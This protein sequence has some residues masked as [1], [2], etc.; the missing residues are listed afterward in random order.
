MLDKV[1]EYKGVCVQGLV[2]VNCREVRRTVF[3]TPIQISHYTPYTARFFRR[4]QTHTWRFGQG[5]GTGGG[6]RSY[7]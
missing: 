6:G 3:S 7:K 4:R 2:F 1:M 5:R